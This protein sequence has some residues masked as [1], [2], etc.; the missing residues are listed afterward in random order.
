MR[1]GNFYLKAGYTHGMALLD[2]ADRPTAIF[3]GSDMQAMGVL[4]AAAGSASMSPASSR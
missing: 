3:A 1:Y 4:R 2:R